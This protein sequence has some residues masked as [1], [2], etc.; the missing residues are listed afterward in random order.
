MQSEWFSVLCNK[1]VE[2]WAKSIKKHET[3]LQT[4]VQDLDGS[5][6]DMAY[7]V[8]NILERKEKSD[9]HS[10]QKIKI[11]LNSATDRNLHSLVSCQVEA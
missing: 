6:S 11:M 8:F 2:I 9:T 5:I 7:I 10:N 1:S 4:I 3:S